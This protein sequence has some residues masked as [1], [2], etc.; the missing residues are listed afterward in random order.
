MLRSP[1]LGSRTT[2]TR[3]PMLLQSVFSL[4]L[5]F[6]GI[7][8]VINQK[9]GGRLPSNQRNFPAEQ[10]RFGLKT[11]PDPHVDRSTQ[12]LRE[13]RDPGVQRVT[14]HS[15]PSLRPCM[16]P[17]ARSSQPLM[18]LRENSEQPL[19]G[20]KPPALDCGSQPLITSPDRGLHPLVA[21]V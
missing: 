19:C 15:V 20:W 9:R 21:Q 2:Q 13:P 18:K 5:P 4:I 8:Y 14:V 6:K 3:T 11:P 17:P 10:T 12:S 16:E 7:Q 1:S